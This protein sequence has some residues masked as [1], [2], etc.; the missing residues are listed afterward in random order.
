MRSLKL[1]HLNV[2]Q[3][4]IAFQGDGFHKELTL[5]FQSVINNTNVTLHELTKLQEKVS[6]I[7]NSRCKT[8]IACH[9]VGEYGGPFIYFDMIE[10]NSITAK[11]VGVDDVDVDS[12]QTLIKN[13]P[14]LGTVNLEL[15][16]VSGFYSKLEATI[17]M[18]T[19]LFSRGHFSAGEIA[20]IVLHEVGH[21]FS[22]CEL[23]D[24][25]AGTNQVLAQMDR[26][27]KNGTDVKKRTVLLKYVGEALNLDQR[28]VQQVQETT[29]DEVAVQVFATAAIKNLLHRTDQISDYYENITPEYTADEFAARHGAGR[30]LVTVTDKLTM[31]MFGGTHI[32]KRTTGEY[33][34]YE[35]VKSLMI[36]FGGPVLTWFLPVLMLGLAIADKS[37]A[38]EPIYDN[39]IQRLNRIRAQFVEQA[40]IPHTLQERNKQLLEDVTI[41]D[42]VL[43]QYTDRKDVLTF[44]TDAFSGKTKD[45]DY[46]RQLEK[47]ASNDLFLKALEFKH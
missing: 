14:A 25:T 1:K 3:E 13:R 21:F 46:Q 40:K 5:A 23:L 43:K 18:P 39:P 33:I 38:G 4:A 28:V 37:D 31:T 9:F 12:F 29:N 34:R 20:A 17:F 35:M 8:S 36:I 32:Q 26:L 44:I 11:Y 42:L 2:A 24:R 30:D 7:I 15:A 47:L 6:K 27:L 22:L 10:P 41:I 16:T 45:R 19:S